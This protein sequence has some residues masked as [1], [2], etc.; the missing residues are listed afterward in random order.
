MKKSKSIFGTLIV[1]SL[2]VLGSCS[3]KEA[4]YPDL[5]NNIR[6][7]VEV[8]TENGILTNSEGVSV[9]IVGTKFAATTDANGIYEIKDVPA[10]NNYRFLAKKEG[11]N[12]YYF[13]SSIPQ[14]GPTSANISFSLYSP[15]TIE[16]SNLTGTLNASKTT[17]SV[18]LNQ[19]KKIETYWSGAVIYF[20]KNSDVSSTNYEYSDYVLDNVYTCPPAGGAC[21]YVY[22][23]KAESTFSISN[24]K[25]YF[26]S[27]TTVYMVTY[28]TTQYF[29]NYGYT[30]TNTGKFINTVLNNKP[31][32]I[33]SIVIP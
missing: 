20:S 17:L 1:C 21:S 18:S 31:S 27:G 28:G 22:D 32:N 9:S 33:V 12:D 26:P 29:Q 19:S 10:D 7:K 3:K 25:K 15:S 14:T 11:L 23:S 2:A 5:K 24:L 13:F 30:D 4:V 16:A 8:Y 6:G